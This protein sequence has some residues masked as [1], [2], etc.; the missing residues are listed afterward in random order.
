[1]H[2]EVIVGAAPRCAGNRLCNG[3]VTRRHDAGEQIRAGPVHRAGEAEPGI[4]RLRSSIG[5]ALGKRGRALLILTALL[6]ALNL[7][8]AVSDPN[9]SREILHGVRNELIGLVETGIS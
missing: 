8:R 5:P 6:G 9:L 7:S 4:L 2:L 1:M 3:S